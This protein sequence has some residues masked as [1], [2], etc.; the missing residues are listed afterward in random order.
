MCGQNNAHSTTV[1]TATALLF[2]GFLWQA[3]TAFPISVN[4]DYSL[5]SVGLLDTDGHGF[6]GADRIIIELVFAR[7]ERVRV[8]AEA[9]FVGLNGQEVEHGITDCGVEAVAPFY[10][11]TAKRLAMQ[12]VANG[13]PVEHRIADPILAS[14]PMTP[15]TMKPPSTT[16][17]TKVVR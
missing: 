4:S 17:T 13:V 12:G 14:T 2:S 1:V 7:C 6:E 9:W 16:S 11:M 15:Q 10:G 3:V 8:L 5:E